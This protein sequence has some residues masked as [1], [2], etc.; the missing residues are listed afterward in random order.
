MNDLKVI[1]DEIQDTISDFN[2]P[3]T[4]Y[5]NNLGLPVEG[6]L[7]PIDER[8]IVIESI[9]REINKISEENREIAVYLTRFLASVTAGLFDGALTYLWNET[10]K[11][12]RKMIINYDLEYFYKVNAENSG[13][14]QN[15]NSEDDLALISDYDMLTTCNR[16]LNVEVSSTS[17]LS[18]I[19]AKFISIF[20]T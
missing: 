1:K 10:I 11:C 2:E 17:I 16:R 7:A 6:I 13:R 12:L 4:Q 18:F 5:L 9:E 15:L 19:F 14:Y 8:K 20:C 3:F